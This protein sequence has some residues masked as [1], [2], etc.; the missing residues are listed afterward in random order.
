MDTNW[1]S[2]DAGS[3]CIIPKTSSDNR[4]V[5]YISRPLYFEIN[6]NYTAERTKLPTEVPSSPETNF[7]VLGYQQK[8]VDKLLSYTLQYGHILYCID[9][10]TSVSSEWGKFWAGYIKTRAKEETTQPACD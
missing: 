6:Q 2:M 10:E 9:N 1:C 5:S 3:G 4:K 7:V 8:F